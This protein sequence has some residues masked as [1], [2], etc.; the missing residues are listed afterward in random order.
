MM[1]IV[2]VEDN[3]LFR[4]AIAAHLRDL[5]HRV[6]EA[7]DAEALDDELV[8]VRP[9]LYLLDVNL[10]GEDGVSLARRLR[11]SD[12]VVGI[13]MLSTRGE[14]ADRVQGYDSG[15]DAYLPKPVVL[16]ELDGVLRALE[17][18]VRPSTGPVFVVDPTRSW[19][20]GPSGGVPLSDTQVALLL[21]LARAPEGTL[22]TWQL[23][24]AIGRSP[25]RYRKASLEVHLARLRERMVQVGG[26]RDAI[27][28]VRGRGY[29]L[30]LPVA[31][32]PSAR[33]S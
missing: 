6:H 13:V 3:L 14:I 21:A 16:D 2:V 22:E 19:I 30:T 12:P 9:D 24:Q 18:R 1:T 11:A 31:V 26:D 20:D 29:R 4:S 27:Q 5:G 17:R 7:D 33:A 23:I 32:G 10:P 8:V 15:A 25:D 28:V